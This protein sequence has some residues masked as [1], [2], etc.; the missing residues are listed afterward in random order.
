MDRIYLYQILFN[1][2][3]LS[4][5]DIRDFI[6]G[7]FAPRTLRQDL[8]F[9]KKLNLVSYKGKGRASRWFLKVKKNQALK[10]K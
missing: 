7:G 10:P 9:L 8:F 4:L 3:Q 6:G 1:N 5:K 2:D